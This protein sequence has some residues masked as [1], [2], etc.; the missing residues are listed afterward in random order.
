MIQNC[1]YTCEAWRARLS[2]S[3]RHYA[4]TQVPDLTGAASRGN[5]VGSQEGLGLPSGSAIPRLFRG[6]L[7]ESHAQRCLF[8]L[9]GKDQKLMRYLTQGKAV[10]K[11]LRGQYEV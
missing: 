10:N 2:R 6:K 7:L 11:C 8:N 4:H 9:L 5:P 1:A 3:N